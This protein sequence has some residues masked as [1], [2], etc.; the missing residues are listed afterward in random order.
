LFETI[1]STVYIFQKGNVVKLYITSIFL[2]LFLGCSGMV[3]ENGCQWTD[4]AIDL[5]GSKL[6]VDW[7]EFNEDP[8]S[9]DDVT[10]DCLELDPNGGVTGRVVSARKALLQPDGKA[11][12]HENIHMG[13]NALGYGYDASH[14]RPEFILD[15]PTYELS[16]EVDVE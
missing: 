7:E 11:A 12:R 16:C 8:G 4:A 13:L 5:V 9:F 6:R 3:T 2:L 10:W 1:N 14:S 15:E